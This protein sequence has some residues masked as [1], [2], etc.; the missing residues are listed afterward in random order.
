MRKTILIL[1]LAGLSGNAMAEWY[2]V[3]E[4]P[5][6]FVYIDMTTARRSVDKIKVWQLGDLK[7]PHVLNDGSKLS[8]LKLQMEYDCEN[9]TV[10]TI[11]SVSY[12][13]GMGEGNILSTENEPEKPTPVV[14]GSISDVLLKVLCTKQ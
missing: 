3:S 10:R 7:T 6:Q 1:L 8:S 11:Y 14:P 12:S 9:E 2:R 13:K 4:Q 5:T